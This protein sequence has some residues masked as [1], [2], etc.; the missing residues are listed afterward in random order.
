MLTSC[1]RTEEGLQEGDECKSED[2]VQE[3]E[4]GL[5]TCGDMMDPHTAATSNNPA[6]GT[7][8]CA[9]VTVGETIQRASAVQSSRTLR[10]SKPT[11]EDIRAQKKMR[12]T[13]V[14]NL[15]K[16]NENPR[17]HRS[18]RGSKDKAVTVSE[19]KTKEGNTGSLQN[20][21]GKKKKNMPDPVSEHVSAY[22]GL[23]LHIHSCRTRYQSGVDAV[24]KFE[25][26]FHSTN[27]VPRFHCSDS[28]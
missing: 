17:K 16:D 20:A 7:P 22:L 6:R 10:T 15:Q 1:P 24:L 5:P 28:K 8:D 14:E 21:K 12:M 9:V 19:P 2:A 13:E 4:D 27:V 25:Y 11:K 18:A 26:I 23:W 3:E